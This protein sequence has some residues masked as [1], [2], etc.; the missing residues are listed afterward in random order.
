MDAGLHRSKYTMSRNREQGLFFD[1]NEAAT[2]QEKYIITIIAHELAHM[3]F[4]NLVT[5]EWWEYT[6]LN[7]GF[8]QYFEYFASE[9]VSNSLHT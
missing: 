3:W 4:G 6:W 1:K 2:S 8:A 7:E 5:C 9:K